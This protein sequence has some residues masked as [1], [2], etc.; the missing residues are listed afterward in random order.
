MARFVVA[1]ALFATFLS[2]G[3]AATQTYLEYKDLKTNTIT[4]ATIFLPPSPPDKK[5]IWIE[6]RNSSDKD[7]DLQPLAALLTARG[8]KVVQD[9]EAANFWLQVNILFVGQGEISAIRQSVLG[10]WGGPLAG[11][12]GGAMIGGAVSKSPAGVGYGIGI[13]GIIGAGVEMVSGSL[14]KTVTYVVVTDIQISEKSKTAV[15]QGQF[16]NI[17][18]GTGTTVTQSTSETSDRRLYRNRIASLATKVNLE[19]AEASPAITQGLLKSLSN[20]F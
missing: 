20:A 6:T 17:R 13:G 7:I 10:G 11:V 8:F 19:F 2:S 15:A 18:Q 9:P 5:T 16:S 4:H 1:I 3:C 12:A 14:V